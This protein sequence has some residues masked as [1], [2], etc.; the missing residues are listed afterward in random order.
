MP[1]RRRAIP[2]SLFLH[3]YYVSFTAAISALQPP[4]PRLLPTCEAAQLFGLLLR[5]PVENVRRMLSGTGA[6]AT[7]LIEVLAQLRQHADAEKAVLARWNSWMI[8]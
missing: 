3:R 8:P 2:G 7:G 4:V 5:A 6:R 1:S